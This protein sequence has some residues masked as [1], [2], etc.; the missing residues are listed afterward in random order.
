[1]VCNNGYEMVL[2]VPRGIN[3]DIMQL[4]Y[5]IAGMLGIVS[6]K[7]TVSIMQQLAINTTL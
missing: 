2:N 7:I 3:G 4:L 6:K 1:M 5:Q